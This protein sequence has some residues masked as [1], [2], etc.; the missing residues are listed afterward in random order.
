MNMSFRRKAVSRNLT[1][2]AVFLFVVSGASALGV[3][4]GSLNPSDLS[5]GETVNNQKVTFTVEGLSGD[6]NTDTF[7][8]R[9]ANVLADSLSVN[10]ASTDKASVT[11]SPELVDGWDNDGVQD[12]VKFSVS[13]DGSDKIDLQGM[14]D[15]SVTY[16]DE[17]EEYPISVHLVDS[18]F[19]EATEQVAKMKVDT[20]SD[21]SQSSTS[22][23]TDSNT[24]SN[25]NT[26]SSS[27]DSNT[28]QNTNS[29]SDD[30]GSQTQTDSSSNTDTNT[31]SSSPAGPSSTD[32]DDSDASSNQQPGGFLAAIVEFFNG[33]F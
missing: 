21:T 20:D 2:L 16:P 33:L 3:N 22:N 6:G 10:S 26:G 13:P 31:G 14:V 25:T 18:E 11:S 4:E 30:T 9:F 5:P 28:N 15:V 19:G 8:V 32:S 12:T 7:Q 17:A 29:G 23:S 27:T 24:N 1:L